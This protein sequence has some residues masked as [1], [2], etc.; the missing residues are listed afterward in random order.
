[1]ASTDWLCVGS[2]MNGVVHGNDWSG[3]KYNELPVVLVAV[4][5]SDS[6]KL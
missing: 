1:M 3:S 2:D 5:D 4:V 6:S